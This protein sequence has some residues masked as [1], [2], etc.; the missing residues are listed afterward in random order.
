MM[1]K[2]KGLSFFD[3]TVFLA[4]IIMGGGLIY[5]Y[6]YRPYRQREEIYLEK[7][8]EY[9][10]KQRRNQ[11]LRVRTRALREYIKEEMGDDYDFEEDEEEWLDQH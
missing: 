5:F 11:E 6:G 4:I 1:K 10:E 2:K 9:Q 3:C 8:R 7:L